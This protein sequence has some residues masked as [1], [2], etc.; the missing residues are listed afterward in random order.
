MAEPVDVSSALEG[1]YV[2]RVPSLKDVTP[3]GWQGAA[4]HTYTRACDGFH[5]PGPCPG[6]DA[7]D[8]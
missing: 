4:Q 2:K 1:F 6:R 5:A 7:S 3:I 8:G